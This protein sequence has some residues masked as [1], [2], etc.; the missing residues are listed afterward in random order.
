MGDRSPV[1]PST[2]AVVQKIEQRLTELIAARYPDRRERPGYGRLAGEICEATGGAISGTYLWQLA[3]G[4]KRNPTLEQLDVLAEFFG[5]PIEYFYNDAVAQ[6]V[7]DR[8]ARLAASESES[9]I[10]ESALLRRQLAEQD[11]QKIAMRAGS[12]SPALRQQLLKMMETLDP[13][14]P[15]GEGPE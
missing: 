14:P 10:A 2:R 3:T 15:Q 7:R 13:K 11:V 4:K 5:V 12:M 6:N 1:R 9:G 8:G